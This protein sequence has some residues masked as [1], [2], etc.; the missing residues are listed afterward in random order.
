MFDLL[1][2]F[3]YE[4]LNDVNTI[5]QL[6]FI[7]LILTYFFLSYD[8]SYNKIILYIIFESSKLHHQKDILF[9]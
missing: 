6:F 5:N 2:I 4:I 7:S 9:F 8:K 1:L 3:I